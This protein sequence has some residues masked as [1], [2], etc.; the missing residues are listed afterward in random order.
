MRRLHT[1][2]RPVDLRFAIPNT[3]TASPTKLA[4]D[5]LTSD[6]DRRR[7]GIVSSVAVEITEL[8]A[9]A[10]PT[11][12][13][14]RAGRVAAGLLATAGGC[15]GSTSSADNIGFAGQVF[16]TTTDGTSG[17]RERVQDLHRNIPAML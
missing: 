17:K 1:V 11:G 4:A 16:D 6:C 8:T 15:N 13:W 10:G 12:R 9:R 3:S 5:V 14:L 7:T 2:H